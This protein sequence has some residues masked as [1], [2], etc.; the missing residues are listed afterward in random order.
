MARF[1]RAIQFPSPNKLER[2]DKPGDDEEERKRRQRNLAP[3]LIP[4]STLHGLACPGHP[5]F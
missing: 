2:P 3:F 5:T 4:V 1:M